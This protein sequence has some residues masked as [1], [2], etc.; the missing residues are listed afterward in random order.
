MELNLKQLIFSLCSL[1]SI[2]GH[3]STA[4]KDLLAL[5]GEYFDEYKQDAVGNQLFIKPAFPGA[6]Q[7]EAG[8]TRIFETLLPLHDFRY[9]MSKS[10]CNRD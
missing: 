3:E 10:G 1:M 7:D 6:S 4:S 8:L 9:Y 2:S 5:V